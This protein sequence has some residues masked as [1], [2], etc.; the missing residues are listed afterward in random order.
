MV[1]VESVL[2][3]DQT[4]MKGGEMKIFKVLFLAVV[5]ALYAASR[6]MAGPANDN[7]QLNWGSQLNGGECGPGKLVVNITYGVTND[8]DSGV[9]GNNWAVDNYNKH[10]QIWQLGDGSFCAIGRYMGDFVTMTGRSPG[11]GSEISSG[12]TGTFEGGWRGTISGALLASPAFKTKGNIGTFDYELGVAPLNVLATYFEPGYG[13]TY[14]FWGWIYNAGDNGK[15]I[16]AD[17]G[18]S[19]DIH[20]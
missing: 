16:N 13:F 4:K 17:T 12:I 18:N 10:I 2:L 8:V 19:G 1:R 11:N 9:A 3:E 15:W 5:M 20:N 14:A 7:P 6:V